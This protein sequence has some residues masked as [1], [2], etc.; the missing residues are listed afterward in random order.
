MCLGS[1]Q[2]CM[3]KSSAKKLTLGE[4]NPRKSK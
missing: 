3:G 4:R 1:V 2:K